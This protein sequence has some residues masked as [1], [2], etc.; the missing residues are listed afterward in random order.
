VVSQSTTSRV[1]SSDVGAY[2]S[3]CHVNIFILENHKSQDRKP[4]Q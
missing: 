1:E 4:T 2:K 3:L